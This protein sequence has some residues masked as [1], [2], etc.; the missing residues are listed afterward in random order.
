MASLAKSKSQADNLSWLFILPIML[1]SGAMFPPID[2]MPSTIANI[3]YSF[4]F[5]RAIDAA[6][7]VNIEGL[8][9]EAINN[10]LLFLAG[11]AVVFFTIGIILF[12]NCLVVSRI[13]GMFL[14]TL[15]LGI[16]AGLFCFG[17]FGGDLRYSNH[18]SFE[19]FETSLTPEDI[20]ISFTK[21]F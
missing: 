4:P 13:R 3:A 5:A 20:P 18:V 12:R 11:F 9:L 15:A 19:G 14:Y 17:F 16:L 2:V 10:D 21:D 1:L 6:R 8:G 7:G